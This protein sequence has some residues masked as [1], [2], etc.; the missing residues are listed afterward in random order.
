VKR[1]LVFI[2]CILIHCVLLGQEEVPVY[3]P[4]EKSDWNKAVDGLSYNEKIIEE[5]IKQLQ[6]NASLKN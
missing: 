3:H 1:L 6:K 4:I 5:E 2:S